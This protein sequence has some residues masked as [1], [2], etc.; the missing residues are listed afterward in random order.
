MAS[1]IGVRPSNLT[2]VARPVVG[3]HRITSGRNRCLDHARRVAVA[4]QLSE[5]AA[6]TTGRSWVTAADSSASQSW[7]RT[8]GRE[9]GLADLGVDPRDN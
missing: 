8:Q 5:L 4:Q 9:D 3:D 2:S 6:K 1:P 7:G